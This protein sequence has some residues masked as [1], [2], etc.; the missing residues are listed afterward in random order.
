MRTLVLASALALAVAL[1]PGSTLAH[2]TPGHG[3][4]LC[5]GT[6]PATTSCTT[7]SHLMTWT[8]AMDLDF[9]GTGDYTGTLEAKLTQGRDT[10]TLTCGFAS[11]VSTGC[12]TSGTLPSA[13]FTFT[14]DCRSYDAGT[15]TP[16]GSGPWKCRIY[17]TV[18]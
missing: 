8:T 6:A 7:G 17:H 9:A 11:G 5:G 1:V 10:Y 4:A 14:H 12:A 15:T 2:V 13:G 18:A 16:G 3:G